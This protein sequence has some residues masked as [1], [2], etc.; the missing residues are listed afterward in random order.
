MQSAC[1]M[2]LIFV[3]GRADTV[4]F[5]HVDVSETVLHWIVV[6]YVVD[7]FSQVQCWCSALFWTSQMPQHRSMEAACTCIV[8]WINPHVSICTVINAWFL[9][10]HSQVKLAGPYLTLNYD[11]SNRRA[12]ARPGAYIW[13]FGTMESWLG[14]QTLEGG[15]MTWRKKSCGGGHGPMDPRTHTFWATTPKGGG[16]GSMDPRTQGF[17]QLLLGGHGPMDLRTQGFGQLLL[18]WRHGPKDPRLWATTPEGGMDPRTQGFG[19]LLLRG[20][21]SMV[22]RRGKTTNTL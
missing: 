3:H 12:C 17:G 6:S 22:R 5:R 19:Q 9:I 16:M 8:M 2:R 21:G 10:V 18:R 13:M 1:I 7:V 20:G 15:S 11:T 4:V 14:E